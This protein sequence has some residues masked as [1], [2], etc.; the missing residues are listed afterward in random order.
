MFITMMS[1]LQE[2]FSNENTIIKFGFVCTIKNMEN[3]FSPG[4]KS[5]LKI[6]QQFMCPLDAKSDHQSTMINV[7]L[8][9][10]FFSHSTKS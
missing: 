8:N 6:I 1:N 9:C 5:V 7:G 10:F 4:K 3:A 2:K